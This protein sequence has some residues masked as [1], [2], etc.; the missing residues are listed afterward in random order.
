MNAIQESMEKIQASEELK[1]TTLQYLDGQRKRRNS[2]H[3]Y[4]ASRYV[5]AAACL[6]VILGIGGYSVY[7]VPVSYISIDV[8][9]SIEL[10][11]NRFGKV[12]WAKAY[13]GD[14]QDI[15]EHI[16]LKNISYV[17]AIDRLLND[18]SYSRFQ[19]GGSQLVFTVISESP[20]TMVKQIEAD[21]YLRMY[22]AKTY[23]SDKACMKEAHQHEM[24]F[25]KYRA[26][27]ELSQY[28]RGIT[29]EDCHSMTMGEIQNRIEDCMQHGEGQ[30]GGNSSGEKERTHGHHHGEGH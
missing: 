14:G 16:S 18:K 10:G 27:L 19:A 1:Q 25:G 20:D 6:L 21:E 26:Y 22:G 23:T 3:L 7:N 2:L 30:H 15:L 12:V 29:V 9:P 17:Q 5:L 13:N 8:N 11:V 4:S 28:D 24:S